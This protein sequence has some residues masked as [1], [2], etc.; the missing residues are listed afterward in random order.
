LNGGGFSPGRIFLA[1]GRP[2]PPAGTDIE[3]QW[4]VVSPD[5]FKTTGTRLLKGREFDK[6]DSATGNLVIIVNETFTRRAIPNEDPLGKRVHSWRDENKL[7]GIVS[8]VADVCYY[9]CDD[10]LRG[11]VYV[12]HAQNTSRAMALNM[13]TQGDPMAGW[14][15]QSYTDR[16]SAWLS[17]CWGRP[18]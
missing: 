16:S 12:P 7:R 6:R 2:E 3:G 10:E 8:V 11:L 14:Q 5:Y 17:G 9:G 15:W 18:H 13:R 1:E 4:N